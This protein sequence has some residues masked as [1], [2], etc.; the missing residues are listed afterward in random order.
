MVKERGF[1]W[2][3]KDDDAPTYGIKEMELRIATMQ[4]ALWVLS[5]YKEKWVPQPD[6]NAPLMNRM[7]DLEGLFS[8]DIRG[9]IYYLV[10]QGQITIETAQRL[11]KLP[12]NEQ[13]E[14]V[15]HYLKPD[16]D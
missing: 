2:T 14:A 15:L 4:R 9:V 6:P 10:K 1:W 13:I 8:K 16:E 5:D 11:E 12:R 7:R 3:E